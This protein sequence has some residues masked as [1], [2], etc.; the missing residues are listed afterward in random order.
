MHRAISKFY[1]ISGQA[2]YGIGS[3]FAFAGLA[4]AMPGAV[5]ASWGMWLEVRGY[6]L[7]MKQDF[8][9]SMPVPKS[10]LAPKN[11]E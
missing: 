2:I 1:R 7:L 6:R 5:I 3:V 4:I 10:S 9:G 11:G 8:S